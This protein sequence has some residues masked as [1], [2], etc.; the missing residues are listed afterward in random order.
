MKYV[1]ELTYENGVEMWNTQD[2]YFTKQQMLDAFRKLGVVKVEYHTEYNEN[3]QH[4]CS[5][6][7][8]VNSTIEN[9]LCDDCKML[10]G[11]HYDYEL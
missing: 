5:C 11:H 6:G 1:Y 2:H 4:L 9:E 10:Y 3:T 7:N 8:V